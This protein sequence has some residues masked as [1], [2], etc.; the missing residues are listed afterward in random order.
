MFVVHC[1]TERNDLLLDPKASYCIREYLTNWQLMIVSILFYPDRVLIKFHTKI[2]EMCLNIIRDLCKPKVALLD[3]LTNNQRSLEFSYLHSTSEVRFLLRFWAGYLISRQELASLTVNKW[4]WA[5]PDRIYEI[6]S[7][8]HCIG[9]LKYARFT[10][11]F[12]WYD[13][14]YPWK[15]FR[16]QTKLCIYIIVLCLPVSKKVFAPL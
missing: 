12:C 2:P 13:T 3:S 4:R 7:V 15:I 9:C 1:R 16:F 8:H 14:E 10:S 11:A 5:C 6:D